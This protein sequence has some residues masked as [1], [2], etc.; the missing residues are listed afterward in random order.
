MWELVYLEEICGAPLGQVRCRSFALCRT[1]KHCRS[2]VTK[3]G[4]GAVQGQ[5]TPLASPAG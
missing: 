2:P 4:P 3:A 5:V 1:M